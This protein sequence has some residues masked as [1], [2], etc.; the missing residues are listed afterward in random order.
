MNRPSERRTSRRL[1]LATTSALVAALTALACVTINV[2][3]PEAAVKD[4]SV[5]IEDAIA[6]EAATQ[7][8]ENGEQAALSDDDRGDSGLDGGPVDADDRYGGRLAS[9]RSAAEIAFGTALH[10]LAPAPAYAQTNQV[11]AP[12][13]TNPAIRE[14][15]DSRAAR[16][17]ELNNFKASGVLGENSQAK[18]EVR[19]LGSLPL[20]QRAAVQKLVRAENS[21]RERMFKE[22]AAATGT[23]LS[24]L[25]Q[26]QSTYA[27][28]LREKARRGDWIELP[29]GT[30]QQKP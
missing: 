18:V 4:L 26:I 24:Q 2:Y 27:Q 8:G 7:A 20:Q 9:W 22:I 1:G 21:D 12:E 19:D 16:V 17:R 5:R 28:T 25:P 29:N 14:I 3:F 11:A 23:D 13:I 30:W 15:I 6:D 10:I